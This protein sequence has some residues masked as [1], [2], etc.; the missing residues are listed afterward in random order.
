MMVIA[1]LLAVLA[2]L[3]VI[4]LVAAD[5]VLMSRVNGGPAEGA[6]GRFLGLPPAAPEAPGASAAADVPAPL[7]PAPRPP[8]PAEV[9]RAHV[10]A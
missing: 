3:V 7:V 2:V 5:P 6:S 9:G 1:A 4:L 10:A 8:A